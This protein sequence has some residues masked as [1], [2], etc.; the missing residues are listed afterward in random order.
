MPPRA[1]HMT[2]STL[3]N[4]GVDNRSATPQGVLVMPVYD[5]R[6]H[7]LRRHDQLREWVERGVYLTL[8]AVLDA[9]TPLQVAM[10]AAGELVDNVVDHADWD[11]P[12]PSSFHAWV[13]FS[14]PSPVIHIAVANP[15]CNPQEAYAT[16]QSAIEKSRTPEDA[17]Q[18]VRDRIRNIR[19]GKV[20]EGS[21]G[22]GL[23]NLGVEG[24]CQLHAELD[25]QNVLRIEAAISTVDPS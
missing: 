13:D 5:L 19:L 15:V 22:L 21:T 6:I 8:E 4:R 1:R 18:A 23:I 7:P 11:H 10:M 24:Y 9:T 20:K 17:I 25:E 3:D 14:G 16:V 2:S 12:A